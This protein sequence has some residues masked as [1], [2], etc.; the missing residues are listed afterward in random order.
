MPNRR[1]RRAPEA[2][3]AEILEA[4][5]AALREVDLAGLTVELLME[6]TGM[7]RS[8]FYHYFKRLDEVVL[9]LFERVE[10]EV[11]GA[12]DA[13][14]EGAAEDASAEARRRLTVERLTRMYEVWQQH[15]TLMRAMEQSAGRGGAAYEGWRTRVVEGYV[16]KTSAFLR[17]EIAAGRSHAPDPEALARTLILMNLS[18]ATEQVLRADPDPPERLGA[19][20]GHV[21]NA[22][23]Y[24]N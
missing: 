2:A 24:G 22:A 23:I 8:S 11:S 9:A 1:R 15:A 18:V 19:V 12:V 3:R 17:R 14:L 13:W 16:E 10:S 5:E 6:R 4:A 20:V 21:W 7:T